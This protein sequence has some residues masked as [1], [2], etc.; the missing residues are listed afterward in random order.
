MPKRGLD[1]CACEVFRFYRLITIKDL[2]E[3]L[4]MIVPRKQSGTFQEDLYPMTAGNQA[5]MT[6]Q[7]WLLGINR[8]QE[9]WEQR[10]IL[11]LR[12]YFSVD[13]GPQ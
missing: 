11:G 7:E 4:S 9:S 5:A 10:L 3:P 6:A 12:R 1:V 2:V 13:Y 8:G